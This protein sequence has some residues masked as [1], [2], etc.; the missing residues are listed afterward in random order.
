MPYRPSPS[1]SQ[2]MQDQSTRGALNALQISASQNSRMM[3][4]QA[5]QHQQQLADQQAMRQASE[6]SGMF[7]GGGGGGAGG[8]MMNGDAGMNG[9]ANGNISRPGSSTGYLQPP[10]PSSGTNPNSPYNG[11]GNGNGIS[12]S[13][14]LSPADLTVNGG[15]SPRPHSPGLHIS[16]PP[17]MINLSQTDRTPGGSARPFAGAPQ[18]L[19]HVVMAPSSSSSSAVVVEMNGGGDV[20]VGDPSSGGAGAGGGAGSYGFNTSGEDMYADLS[21]DFAFDDFVNDGLF[22]DG[23]LT[24]GLS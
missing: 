1:P 22:K 16:I 15:P 7:G 21:L 19:P 8:E 12:N 2:Q 3:A 4:Q 13:N 18:Q 23:D 10:P 6:G 5:Q 14:G 20:Q 24:E 9:H 11:N 17:P